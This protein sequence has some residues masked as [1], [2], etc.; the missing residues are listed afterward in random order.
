MTQQ[1]GDG[2]LASCRDTIHS[3]GNRLTFTLRNWLRW[4]PRP[5]QEI[6][7][8]DQDFLREKP[9]SLLKAQALMARYDLSTLRQRA[10]A[11]RFRENL[12]Y[13]EWLD[14][15]FQLIPTVLKGIAAE[16]CLN[17]LDVGAKNW[18]YADAL[19]AFLRRHCRNAYRL[20]GLEL[21]PNRR[22]TDL[23]TRIQAAEA[24]VKPLPSAQYHG[25][26]AMLWRRKAHIISQFLPFVVKKPLL[27]WGLPLNYFQPRELL[28]HLLTL[29]EPGGVLFVVN[30]GE[31][32]MEAQQKLWAEQADTSVYQV[33]NLGILPSSFMEYRYPRYGWI[34]VKQGLTSS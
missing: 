30:Q 20:D 19:D 6:A 24:Y 17:W 33:W 23:T 9:E 28:A 7:E 2:L 31:W 15:S 11:Q 22:Y 4:Q 1:E 8:P 32:E 14:Y 18:A 13:L 10:T 27:A 3:G 21:D 34:C 29:L 12:A 16:P 26:D 5:F 25:L